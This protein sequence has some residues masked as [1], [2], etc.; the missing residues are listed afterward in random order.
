MYEFTL[1]VIHHYRHKAS[2]SRTIGNPE[3]DLTNS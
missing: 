3:E 1:S 2:L